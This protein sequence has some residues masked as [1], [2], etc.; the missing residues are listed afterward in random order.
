VLTLFKEIIGAIAV[1][2]IIKLPRL[3][4]PIS[5]AEVFDISVLSCGASLARLSVKMVASWLAR[6]MET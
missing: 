4:W 5:K 3:G 6:E 1:A 2:K